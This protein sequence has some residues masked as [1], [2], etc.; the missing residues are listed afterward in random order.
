MMFMSCCEFSIIVNH[1]Q[2]C[3][4]GVRLDLEVNVNY[5]LM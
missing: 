1:S 3:M 5:T 4:H 2:H